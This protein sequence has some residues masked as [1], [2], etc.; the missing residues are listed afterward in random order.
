MELETIK[1]LLHTD[2]PK[3]APVKTILFQEMIWPSL[4]ECR[5]FTSDGAIYACMYENNDKMTK[6]VKVPEALKQDSK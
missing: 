3:A 2:C 4:V 5:I 6:F 1:N